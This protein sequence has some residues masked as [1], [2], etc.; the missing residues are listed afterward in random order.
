M[1]KSLYALLLCVFGCLAAA[2]APRTT[3]PQATQSPPT[4]VA[5]LPTMTLYVQ[6]T[7]PPT[8][9][10]VCPGAPRTRLILQERAWVLPDDPRPVNMR[11]QPG[12]G[13]TLVVQIPIKAVFFV[14]DGPTCLDDYAWF[15]VRYN[16]K[17]GWV[18]EGDLTSYYVEPYLPG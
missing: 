16:N 7:V 8:P 13:N 6:P 12:T 4:E 17:T 1:N 18:A 5:A 2:C 11:S 10:P 15:Q 3:P 9:T 14:L